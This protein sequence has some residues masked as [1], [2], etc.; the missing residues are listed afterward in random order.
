MDT[1]LKIII[2][3]FVCFVAYGS[4]ICLMLS[5]TDEVALKEAYKEAQNF[6]KTTNL[7]TLHL[8]GIIYHNQD[9]WTVWVNGQPLQAGHRYDSFRVLKV[10][11]DFVEMI[12][13]PKAND[14]HQILLRPNEVYRTRASD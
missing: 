4:D 14:L 1:L 6:L 5:P 10:T 11:P 3:S 13:I 7:N 2:T 9:S 8:G 12:W